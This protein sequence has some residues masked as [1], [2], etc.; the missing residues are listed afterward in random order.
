MRLRRL[1]LA[2]ALLATTIGVAPAS[3]IT[4]VATRQLD[5]RLQELTL[6][7]PALAAPTHVRVLL[8]TGYAAS[9]SRRYP[10]LYLLNGSL[11]DYRSWTVN[12][13]AEQ[14]TARLPVIVVMPDGGSG[15][16]YSDWYNGGAGGPPEWE[17]YHIGQLIPWIDSR[18]R[19]LGKRAGRAIAGLSM[20]GF[21]A[22]SYAAR[23]PD[24]F[25]AAASFSG[26]VDT[27]D[28]PVVA[29]PDESTFDS[30]PPFAT[31]GPRATQ[32]LIWRAH[33]PWDLAVNLRGLQLT[34]R[35]GNGLPGGAGGPYPYEPIAGAVE[36]LVHE[37]NVDLH[38]RL[39]AL[40][41]AHVWQDY[42]P[43]D[44]SWPYWDRDLALTLPDIMAAFA[45][46]PAP[47]S[48][49]TFTAAER[50]YD[51]YGWRVSMDRAADEFSTLTVEGRGGFTL[52]GSGSALVRTAGA[53]TPR[54]RYQVLVGATVAQRLSADAGGRLSIA[55]PLGPANP[56]QQY[57]LQADLRGTKRYSTRVRISAAPGRSEHPI[58]HP[59]SRSSQ[60]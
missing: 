27:N 23:H 9:R 39:E 8:P 40:G 33:D 47:P 4:L 7:T 59:S 55:V 56:D 22:L 11:S 30:R 54:R 28:P 25:V 21:G 14:Q 3:A 32:E 35:T 13:D 2:T 16:F 57:S 6:T 60:G 12:G 46:P 36:T 18:Y 49:F 41:I 31:W 15:G 19:T 1:A 29:E 52:T 5:P 51:V 43:G 37:E 53:Y 24:L 48:A 42:G 17:T 10:V 58:E 50:G 26:V 45:H 34:L 44:H 38:T 20:G